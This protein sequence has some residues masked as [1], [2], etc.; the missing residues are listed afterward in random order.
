MAKS[1]TETTTPLC[2]MSELV[3]GELGFGASLLSSGHKFYNLEM[4]MY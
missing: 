2:H 4:S 3:C 1:R